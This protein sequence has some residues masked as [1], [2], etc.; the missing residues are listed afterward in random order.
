MNL[1]GPVDGGNKQ[2]VERCSTRLFNRLRSMTQMQ[3]LRFRP[4]L[5]DWL[6]DAAGAG[7]MLQGKRCKNPVSCKAEDIDVT[8]N[9]N[10]CRMCISTNCF[11]GHPENNR[12]SMFIETGG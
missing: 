9:C 12:F 3:M 6:H 5:R 4:W 11:A 8:S 10:M 7:T 1:V 2:L